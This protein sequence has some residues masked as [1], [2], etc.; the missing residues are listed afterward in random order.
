MK[1][2]DATVQVKTGIKLM[3]KTIKKCLVVGFKSFIIHSKTPDIL[4]L[5]SQTN[6]LFFF[7]HKKCIFYI[8]L[9]KNT[10]FSLMI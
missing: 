5:I 4:K 2:I 6:A 7:F 10:Y 3:T 1:K 9:K 8:I